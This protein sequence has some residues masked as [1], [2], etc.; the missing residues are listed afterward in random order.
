MILRDQDTKLKWTVII[1]D[2]RTVIPDSHLSCERDRADHGVTIIPTITC[3]T[4]ANRM[5]SHTARRSYVMITHGHHCSHTANGE[6]SLYIAIIHAP[7]GE[8]MRWSCMLIMG[9]H[10]RSQPYKLTVQYH[11]IQWLSYLFS[12]Y[13]P[14]ISVHHTTKTNILDAYMYTWQE[15]ASEYAPA[16]TVLQGSHAWPCS[17]VWLQTST[18]LIF[19]AYQN[20]WCPSMRSAIGKSLDKMPGMRHTTHAKHTHTHTHTHTRTH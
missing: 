1:Y 12:P 8:N 6:W 16:L 10:G 11:H 5:N 3:N 17:F 14:T 18:A 13:I 15:Y 4:H 20:W 19:G 9:D 2:A 7:H